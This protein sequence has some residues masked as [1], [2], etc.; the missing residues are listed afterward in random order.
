MSEEKD[1][2]LHAFYL[3]IYDHPEWFADAVLSCQYAMMQRTSD[4]AELRTKYGT[5]LVAAYPYIG[6]NRKIPEQWKKLIDEATLKASDGT[7][8]GK[9]LR[10]ELG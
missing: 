7:E 1:R 4:E 6:K 3:T 9:K 5:A 2:F 10:E 8:F